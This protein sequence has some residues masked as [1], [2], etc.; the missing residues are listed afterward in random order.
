MTQKKALG[1][2][3][4][5]LF[6]AAEKTVL[7]VPSGSVEEGKE[8]HLGI[9]MAFVHQIQANPYQPRRDFDKKALEELTESIRSSGL[10]QPLIVKKTA[11]NTFELIAGER[12][13]K[14]AQKAGLKQVPVVIRRSTD[15]ESLELALVENIQRQD[16]NCV[17]EALAYFRLTQD[18]SLTQEEVAVRVGKERATVAN[19]LRLLRLSEV[20]LEDLKNGSLSFGHGK[21]LLALEDPQHRMMVRAKILEKGLSV[22][23]TEARIAEMKKNEPL[24]GNEM[25][26]PTSMLKNR[27]SQLSQELTRQWS[28]RVEIKG[29]EKSGKI[30]IYYSTQQDL[31]RILEA[32]HTE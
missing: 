18:F 30:M 26:T 23:D 17:D 13:W 32:M 12:R 9:S 27:L 4:A 7:A 16:L 24:K 1:K 11:K 29:D 10:I 19:Y 14:A 21:A 6:P 20:I 8:R 28:T 3:L 25:P 15:R 2:G 31:D 22:R 5:S